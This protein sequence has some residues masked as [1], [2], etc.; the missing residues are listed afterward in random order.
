[1]YWLSHVKD[2]NHEENSHS[3]GHAVNLLTLFIKNISPNE[4]GLY[5]ELSELK[6]TAG[7]IGLV[8]GIRLALDDPEFANSLFD[9]AT[10]ERERCDDEN[11]VGRFIWIR[12]T[13]NDIWSK[14][15]T[16]SNN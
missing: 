8:S 11:L 16:H 1:M 3:W 7:S 13:I 6:E 15:T 14:K 10:D 4:T 2:F 9:G 5:A 12:D